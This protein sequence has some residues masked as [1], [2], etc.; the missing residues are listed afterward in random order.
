MIMI[1]RLH[2]N[3]GLSEGLDSNS[4]HYKDS[5]QTTATAASSLRQFTENP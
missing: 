5:I 2:R 3:R 4:H 1:P